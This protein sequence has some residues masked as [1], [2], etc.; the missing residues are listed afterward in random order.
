[1]TILSTGEIGIAAKIQE[2][3]RRARAGQE[4]RIIDV[5]ADAEC[6]HGVFDHAEKDGS[7]KLA[8]NLKKA[9][10]SYYGVAGPAF[11][12]AIEDRGIET[13]VATIRETQEAFRE[14]V[15]RDVPTGQVLRVADRFGLVAAAGELAIELGVLPWQAGAARATKVMFESWHQDRGGN[16]PAEVHTAIE[17]IRGLFE[18]HGDGRF[19]PASLDPNTR[20]VTDRLGYVHS[21]GS[22]RQW[23]IL[24]ETWRGVLCLGFDAKTTA[25]ALVKRGLLLAGEDGKTSRLVRVGANVMRAYVLPAKAWTEGEGHH[26]G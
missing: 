12:K 6:G 11:V 9:A 4:V 3:G 16:D 21:E 23:W 22:D 8:D 7:K 24:P 15:V 10:S 17:Q 13:V 26:A 20:P 1:M 25:K 18:R 14:G 19:D 5:D 2:T